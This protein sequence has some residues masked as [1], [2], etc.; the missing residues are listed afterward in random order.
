MGR[1]GV[2]AL[3][4][5]GIG[6]TPIDAD[7]P[8]RYRVRES[9]FDAQID[10]LE[11]EGSVL[12]PGGLTGASGVVLTFD[13][14]DR[15]VVDAILPRMAARGMKG[16]LFMTT[17]FIGRRGYLDAAALRTLAGSGW[18]IGAHGH[19]HRFL[20]LLSPAE[21]DAELVA[22]R[23]SLSEI[24]DRAPTH[25]SFPGGRTSPAVEAAA[26][27]HGF[28]TLWS[29][30]PG[31]NTVG[32]VGAPLR[33]T[34]VRRGMSLG[35]FVRLCRGEPFTQLVDELDM[36]C[37]TLVKRAVGDQRYHEMTHRLLG[38]IGRR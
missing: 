33:R 24:L 31:V 29:S 5:H 10:V 13:D 18:L 9:E 17:S 34:V 2:V 26:R 16:A 30:R 3:M 32:A 4:Y 12:D 11:R 8:L 38:A 20:N 37:R 36:G 35:S 27:A 6:D 7:D 21:L 23:A 19:T 22:A 25:L 15:T 14:G 1:R 28:A